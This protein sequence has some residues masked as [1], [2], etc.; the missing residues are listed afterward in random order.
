MAYKDSGR[1]V[2]S[3]QRPQKQ[4]L[5]Y[6]SAQRR[7]LLPGAS[8][9]PNSCTVALVGVRSMWALAPAFE[10]TVAAACATAVGSVAKV[11]EE[12]FGLR[13]IVQPVSLQKQHA[14]LHFGSLICS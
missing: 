1:L 2:R 13:L 4:F 14:Y 10:V 7:A 9:R 5:A 12:T 6:F 11:V 8:A 3:L